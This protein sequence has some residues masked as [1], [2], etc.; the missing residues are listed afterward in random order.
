MGCYHPIHTEGERIAVPWTVE[1]FSV[2]RNLAH[3][4][5]ILL[6]QLLKTLPKPQLTVGQFREL[7]LIGLWKDRDDIQDSACIYTAITGASATS[8]TG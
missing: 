6:T 3:F 2:E 1:H 7:G 4:K 5:V 8:E